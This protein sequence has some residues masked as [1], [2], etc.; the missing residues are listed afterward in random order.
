MLEKLLSLKITY[1]SHPLILTSNDDYK[2]LDH[3]QL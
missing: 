1:L 2:I 3:T